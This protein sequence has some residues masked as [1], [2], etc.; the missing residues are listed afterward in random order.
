MNDPDQEKLLVFPCEFP[1][2]VMG[3]DSE[4]FRQTA[5]ALVEEHAG[6]VLDDAIKTSASSKGNFLSI[7]VTITATSQEQLDNIYQALSDHDEIL[8]AL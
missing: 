8:V 2:K 6:K 1:I 4:Q 3:R 5:I 7:T